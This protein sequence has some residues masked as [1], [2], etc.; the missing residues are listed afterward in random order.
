MVMVNGRLLMIGGWADGTQGKKLTTTEQYA[1]LLRQ[2]V[3]MLVGTTQDVRNSIK[4]NIPAQH[5]DK[6]QI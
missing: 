5:V 3:E 2:L 1:L 4:R 6:V